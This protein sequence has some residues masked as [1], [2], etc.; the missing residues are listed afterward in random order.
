YLE[1]ITRPRKF[2]SAARAAS[3]IKPVIAIKAGRHSEAALAAA[4]HTGALSGA[5]R[6]VDA[7]LRRA[8]I[9]R[10]DNLAELFDAAEITA[11]FPAL[12]R[13]RI[14]IVTNGGG[15]G[16]LAV[17]RLMD[18]GGELAELSPETIAQ[19]DRTMP[20]TWSRSNPVDII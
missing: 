19:L 10:V 15:A 11:Q 6:V 2:M 12:P 13:A 4:T 20:P 14:G 7:A 17:D 16:V 1:T 3:R 9:L 8:G 5:D 18:R